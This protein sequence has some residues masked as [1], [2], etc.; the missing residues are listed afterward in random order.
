MSQ[1]A[2]KVELLSPG[3]D[4][5]KLKQAIRYGADACYI[6]GEAY[7]LRTRAGNFTP[8]EM[9]EALDFAHQQEAKVY[10][11]ANLV[12]HEG[13]DAD[14][15][16]YFRALESLGV[17]AVLISDPGLIAICQKV[18]S[19][20]PI[21]LST[22]AS[23]LNYRA[24]NFWQEQ[25]LERVVLGRETSLEEIR[26]LKAKCSI[27]LEYFVHGAMCVSYS[28]RC[29]LSNYLLLRDANRGGCAQPCRW[30]YDLY[31]PPT[32]GSPR[33]ASRFSLS[34]ADLALIDYLPELLKAGV[35]SLKIEG[36]MKSLH[37][38]ATVTNVYRAAIDRYY[39]DPKAYREDPD[40]KKELAKAAQRQL[41]TGFLLGRPTAAAQSYMD[42]SEA[43]DY[44]FVG[45]VL[46]YDRASGLATLEQRGK[47]CVGDT[48]EFFGP[49]MFHQEMIV[50]WMMNEEGERI[51]ACPH[52][53][54]RFKLPVNFPVEPY[55]LVRKLARAQ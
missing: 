42:Q 30:T 48:L 52:P 13:E 24:L 8:E 38:V 54:M 9:A 32:G 21:H 2:K 31:G 39:A 37:Y 34:A 45:L 25:G 26:E 1:P 36:R 12:A 28:G 15:A 6:A 33:L 22:Q 51:E 29:V 16:D 5:E 14:A 27:E 44:S 4:L 19:N 53:Q 18:A 49:G 20:L 35:D 46:D 55:Y 17:D 3:G 47:F 40:W 43:K 50:P 11:V 23:A 10:V 7:G 41:S